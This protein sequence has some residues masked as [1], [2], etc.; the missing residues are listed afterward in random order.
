MPHMASKNIANSCFCTKVAT[1]ARE[2]IA[3][4]SKRSG[5]MASWVII[6][7]TMSMSST[8]DAKPL[9]APTPSL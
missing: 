3:S 9:F 1:R 5:G 7:R 8:L 2:R 6:D 4:S